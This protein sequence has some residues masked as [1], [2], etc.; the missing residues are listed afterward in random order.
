MGRVGERPFPPGE[1]DVVVV[2]TG[3]G[4]LQTSHFLSRFGVDHAVVS[5]DDGPGGMFRAWPIFGRLLSRSKP[6]APAPPGSREYER[7]DHNSLIAG[8]ADLGALV[9]GE[10]DRSYATPSREE[11]LRG[12]A[13]FAEASGIVARYGCRWEDTSRDADGRLVLTT[14]DGAYTCG[15]AVF[16]LGVT[17]PWRP[18]VPGLEDVPHYADTAE[19]SFYRAKRV[20]IIGKRNSGFELASGL[21]PWAREIVLISPRAV[22]TDVLARSTVNVRYFEPL[23]EHSFGGGTFAIDAAVEGIERTAGGYRIHL[24]GTHGAGELTIDCDEAIAA[25]GFT[26]PFNDLLDLG[27]KA[28]A[29]GRIPALTPFFEANGAPGV[30]F[31]GNA[32]QGA[33]GL[34]KDSSYPMS[35]AVLGFRY[36][37]RLLAMELARRFDGRPPTPVPIARSDV[38]KLL[39][40]ELASSPELWIQKGYLARVITIEADDAL[41]QGVLPLEHV[42]DSMG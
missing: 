1:Y 30:F 10:M 28:V 6:D 14:T 23:E 19:P 41:D 15:A 20:G 27:V 5:A 17:T 7:Y 32:S 13:R 38:A 36:N 25:T 33:F 4:G 40:G 24:D 11:M 39:C 26:T 42:L 29:R 8:E 37:A 16:A 34:R 12:L 2:G 3:P 35:T 21:L 22:R 31:A 18:D 9:P